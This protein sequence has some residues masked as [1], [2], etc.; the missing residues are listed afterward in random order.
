[1]VLVLMLIDVV[2]YIRVFR[3][4]DVVYLAYIMHHHRI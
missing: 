3:H 1:M 2:S 4:L